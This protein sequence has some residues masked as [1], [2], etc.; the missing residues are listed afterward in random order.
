MTDVKTKDVIEKLK[1]VREKYYVLM[2]TVNRAHK[3]I[4]KE[5]ALV[6]EAKES[7]DELLYELTGSDFYKP[8]KE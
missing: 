7:I 8:Q 6:T 2:H 4:K 3:N 1:N 5:I